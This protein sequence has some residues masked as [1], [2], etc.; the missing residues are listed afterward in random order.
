MKNTNLKYANV[1]K[2]VLKRFIAALILFAI[3]VIG[4]HLIVQYELSQSDDLMKVINVSGRQRMLSQNINKS[5]LN[6]LLK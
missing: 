2:I 1:A 5:Y 6:R 3:L 4:K